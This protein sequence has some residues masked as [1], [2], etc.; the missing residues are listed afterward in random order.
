VA[1][2]P[3]VGL[4]RLPADLPARL[5]RVEQRVRVEHGEG[6]EE[7]AAGEGEPGERARQPAALRGDAQHR[8]DDEGEEHRAGRVLGRRGGAD[9]R[10]GQRPVAPASPLQHE[11][12]GDERYGDGQERHDVVERVLG[13]EDRQEG[14]G[15]ERR[16]DKAGARIG[17]APPG[18]V[19]EP[20]DQ[21]AERRDD[22]ARGLER[23]ARVGGERPRD[24]LAR[25]AQ[26]EHG[27]EQVGQRGR[28]LVV[29][30]IEALAGGHGDRPG[31]EVLGLVGVVGERQTVVELP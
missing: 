17:V 26:R 15:H 5:R 28:V 16:R 18:P 24:V 7:G 29:A 9:R 12:A 8:R 3:R 25:V 19:R 30:G 21:C 13:V 14:D 22:D 31:D 11:Q 20:H 1:E 2:L 4:A 27:R 10:A 6:D 23:R